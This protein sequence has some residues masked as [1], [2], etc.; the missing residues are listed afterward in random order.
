MI[1]QGSA[2]CEIFLFL[3]LPHLAQIMEKSK[4]LESKVCLC[5]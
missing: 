2:N 1:I 3:F 4:Y 5:S